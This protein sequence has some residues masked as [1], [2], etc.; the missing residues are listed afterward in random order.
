MTTETLPECFLQ[1]LDR[2]GLN[3]SNECKFAHFCTMSVVKKWLY[4]MY[5]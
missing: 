5:G 3:C 2:Y 4:M 1:I